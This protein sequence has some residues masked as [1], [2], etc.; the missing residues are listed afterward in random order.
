MKSAAVKDNIAEEPGMLAPRIKVNWTRSNGMTRM[1]IYIL[2]ISE[3][4]QTGIGEF[5]LDDHYNYSCGQE[6]L[7]RNGIS[8][9]VNKRV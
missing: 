1:N 7:R 5:N 4:K 9:I 2:G 3:L 6:F 8:L